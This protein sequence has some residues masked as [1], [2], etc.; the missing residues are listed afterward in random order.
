MVARWAGLLA[1][2]PDPRTRGVV[3]QHSK[4]QQGVDDRGFDAFPDSITSLAS[5]QDGLSRL[6]WL[7]RAWRGLVDAQ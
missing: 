5:Q 3:R 6:V 7:V 4:N 2:E 1:D